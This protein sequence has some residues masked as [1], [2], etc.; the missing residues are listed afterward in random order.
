VLT[1]KPTGAPLGVRPSSWSRSAVKMALPFI[2]MPVVQSLARALDCT[3]LYGPASVMDADTSFSCAD[4]WVTIIRI[5]SCVSLGAWLLVTFALSLA[6]FAFGNL[7]D[8]LWKFVPT[9]RNLKKL[10]ESA[11]KKFQGDWGPSTDT[12]PYKVVAELVLL[13]CTCVSIMA[14]TYPKTRCAVYFFAH[15]AGLV[16]A[17]LRPP[18]KT[19][20]VALQAIIGG[21][22][23]SVYAS[24]LCLI[25]IATEQSI[26]PTLAFYLVV[27]GPSFGIAWRAATGHG[28][29]ISPGASPQEAEQSV[30][31]VLLGAPKPL[32]LGA[33]KFAEKEN[34]T[35]NAKPSS[36][37]T[38][39]QCDL[40]APGPLEAGATP[41]SAESCNDGCK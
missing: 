9:R 1:W 36:V 18:N 14:T 38:L 17:W 20:T 24:T 34:V 13:S 26:Y 11:P 30:Q 7:D 31:P 32:P 5:L 25:S 28:Q 3:P 4:T 10:Q 40:E 41:D 12:V 33:E 16:T 35:P 2:K 8:G 22:A 21:H 37:E 29:G 39:S 23:A 27:L 6:G 19:G 15:L